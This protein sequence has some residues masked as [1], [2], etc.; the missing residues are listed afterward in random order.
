MRFKKWKWNTKYRTLQGL[1]NML[2][3]GQVNLGQ[4]CIN[5]CLTQPSENYNLNLAKG[6][7]ISRVQCNLTM[8]FYK[9]PQCPCLPYLHLLCKI[10]VRILNKVRSSWHFVLKREITWSRCWFCSAWSGRQ[11]KDKNGKKGSAM[12]THPHESWH[13]LT[14]RA[15]SRPIVMTVPLMILSKDT[16][17]S[18][19]CWKV[20][21]WGKTNHSHNLETDRILWLN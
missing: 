4:D 14:I 3:A 21:P 2:L 8:S 18:W 6:S 15:C 12:L 10:K 5:K 11:S 9:L 7:W 13:A 20:S 17:I 1:A 19:T 16:T